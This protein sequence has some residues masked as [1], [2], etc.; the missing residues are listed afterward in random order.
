MAAKKTTAPVLTNFAVR[1]SL[2]PTPAVMHSIND[3]GEASP[4]KVQRTSILGTQGQYGLKI[5]EGKDIVSTNNIQ[6]VD[7]AFMS[8]NSAVLRVQFG[9]KV[10]RLSGNAGANIEMC[11]IPEVEQRICQLND[12]YAG[13]GGFGYLAS[14]YAQ[15]IASG[16]WLWRNR[17]GANLVVKV[18]ATTDGEKADEFV[19]E[20]GGQ[21]DVASLGDVIGLG[22]TGERMVSLTITAE[23][24]LGRGQEVFPSQQM[25]T[26]T[27]VSRVYYADSNDNAMMHSQKLGNAIR[28]IDIWHDAYNDVGAIP[29][30]PYGSSIRNQQAYRY[31]SRSF[32]HLLKQV[33][34]GEGPLFK[35]LEA[36]TLSDLEAIQDAH[37]FF[38]MLCRGG[39]FG[40]KDK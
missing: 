33:L 10:H 20:G 30:E 17:Y 15:R 16:S 13:A 36:R 26:N 8:P 21:Q 9:L 37:Y 23:V 5:K 40:M 27:N 6:E 22:L 14:L 2:N 1:R 32:Y 29:V 35:I 31:Q 11:N 4:I 28:T 39:V 18:S 19:Y 12:A 34:A 38:A 24:E 7:V 25:A 3:A